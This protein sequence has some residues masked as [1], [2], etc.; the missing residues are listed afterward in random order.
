MYLVK[1]GL[2]SFLRLTANS[3]EVILILAGRPSLSNCRHLMCH[4]SMSV[5]SAIVTY[6]LFAVILNIDGAGIAQSFRNS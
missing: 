2:N 4:E 5:C 3:F 1:S 6:D